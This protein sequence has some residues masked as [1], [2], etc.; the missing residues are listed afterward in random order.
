[1]NMVKEYVDIGLRATLE[2]SF[3]EGK[4]L[5]TQLLSLITSPY[6]RELEST[7]YDEL[8]KQQRDLA[9]YLGS[10]FLEIF[11]GTNDLNR[12]FTDFVKELQV[13]TTRLSLTED[14]ESVEQPSDVNIDTSLDQELSQYL[15]PVID[16][17]KT[18]EIEMDET[19][20]PTV[21]L[22]SDMIVAEHTGRSI[23]LPDPPEDTLDLSP[24][25]E[26]GFGGS[27][28]ESLPEL[29]SKKVLIPL[30]DR[31]LKRLSDMPAPI[32][33]QH[34]DQFKDAFS[35]VQRIADAT[36]M[37]RWSHQSAKLAR[38]LCK[39]T[40]NYTRY[41][42]HVPR[43]LR[44]HGMTGDNSFIKVIERVTA[45]AK[46]HKYLDIN[47]LKDADQPRNEQWLHDTQNS[48]YHVKDVLKAQFEKAQHLNG[49][50][51]LEKLKKL[52][53]LDESSELI[54][55]QVMTIIQQTDV[56]HHDQR[57]TKLL[58][59]YIDELNGGELRNLRV[60]IRDYIEQ[61]DAEEAEPEVKEVLFPSFAHKKL[62]VIGGDR[63]HDATQYLLSL[64]PE[65][66]DL[67]WLDISSSNGSNARQSLKKSIETGGLDALVMIKK[68]ISH[69]V[70]EPIKA[71]L[72][73]HPQCKSAM[74]KGYGKAQLKSALELLAEHI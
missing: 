58:V 20:T 57:L 13:N 18:S 64:L 38:A 30:N 70:T 60:A 32:H 37:D 39:L 36:Y 53:L 22:I 74:A 11:E 26:R 56:S 41:L 49:D 54:F 24:L 25:L 17:L 42:L 63:R 2:S 14:S 33:I 51:Q 35:W 68:Y 12:L 31:L 9:L 59:N 15:N 8:L 72:K 27:F 28:T 52:V 19:L 66:V 65:S 69:S 1:M 3:H 5:N 23:E 71:V 10:Y 40:V 73:D 48:Y 45:F 16:P 61:V 4:A 6:H 43:H 62:V 67:T 34:P 50:R 21:N 46:K 29:T 44:A 7:T 47:G 55:E